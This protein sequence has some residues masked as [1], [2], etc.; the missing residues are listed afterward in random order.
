M[1]VARYLTCLIMLALMASCG[2]S[3]VGKGAFLPEHIKRVGVPP[4]RDKT[5]RP[6]LSETLTTAVSDKLIRQSGIE[7]TP[8]KTG[9]DAV[10]E[11]EILRVDRTPIDFD[12]E[13]Y[14][15]AYQITLTMEVTLRDL[16]EKEDIYNNSSFVFR[17][18]YEV[19][20]DFED[21]FDTSLE[22][23]EEIA[24][25]FADQLVATILEGF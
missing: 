8:N 19:S 6:D 9:V 23:I 2:Y 10:L 20:E 5:G 16:I 17:S 25:D 18:E 21:F 12:S 24:V 4:F 11:G 13:G 15:S 22:G 14:A 1:N 3:L 7:V